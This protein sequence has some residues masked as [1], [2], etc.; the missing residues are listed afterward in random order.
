M[1]TAA[2]KARKV[3]STV[4]FFTALSMIIGAFIAAAMAG[5]AG[6]LRDEAELKLR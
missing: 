3:S 2:D 4:S 5:Y 1:R 6:R